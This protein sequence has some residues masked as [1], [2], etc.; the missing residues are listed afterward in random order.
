[1]C[2]ALGV[3]LPRSA[4][5]RGVRP[6]RARAGRQQAEG[7]GAE[8]RALRA[9]GRQLDADARDMLDHARGDLDQA[10]PDGR[11]LAAGERIG[12]ASIFSSGSMRKNERA[13]IS[14]QTAHPIRRPR[15]I[16]SGFRMTAKPRLRRRIGCV[17]Q[18]LVNGGICAPTATR[19]TPRPN[20][21]LRCWRVRLCARCEPPCRPHRPPPPSA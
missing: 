2:D 7:D 8:Q 20:C 19:R 13:S 5:R 15:L 18:A 6:L 1:L 11:E 10:L 4:A 21:I 17:C 14:A 12:V 16:F 9:A 3:D